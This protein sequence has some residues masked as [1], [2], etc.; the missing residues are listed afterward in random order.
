MFA[1]YTYLNNNND[2]VGN[3]NTKPTMSAFKTNTNVFIYFIYIY[4]IIDT[5]IYSVFELLKKKKKI[6]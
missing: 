4:I 6:V 3:N 1:R 2:Q 5:V